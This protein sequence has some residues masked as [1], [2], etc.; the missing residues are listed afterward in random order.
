MTGRLAIDTATALGSVA[1]ASGAD[2]L[3]EEAVAPRQGAGG[4]IPAIQR[5]L[6]SGGVTLEQLDEIVLAD[7][8]GSF[9]G[10]RVGFATV[11]GLVTGTPLPVRIIPSLVATAWGAV[12]TRA[13]RV[14]ATTVVALYN[15]L[16]GEVFAT[17]CRVVGER[18]EV[19][20]PPGLTTVSAL[21]ETEAAPGVVVSADPGLLPTGGAVW[22][23]VE[24][25]ESPDAARAVH[26]LSLGD[27]V[28]RRTPEWSEAAIEPDYGRPAAAQDRWEQEHG[29]AISDS[30]GRRR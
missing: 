19:I 21:M 3:A 9:T 2:V 8:P 1:L 23:G 27:R 28:G 6:R 29:R 25:V 11:A 16:R 17:R 4:L 12:A 13:S 7:G 15:A 30:P 18:F 20:V 24:V 26:L 10:L 5:C 22:A 14:P